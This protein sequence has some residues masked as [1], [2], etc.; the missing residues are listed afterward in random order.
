MAI[1]FDL[2]FIAYYGWRWSWSRLLH[3]ALIIRSRDIT[4]APSDSEILY[5]ALPVII[6][7]RYYRDF[8]TEADVKLSLIFV[9][10]DRVNF[11]SLI[12]KNIRISKTLICCQKKLLRKM[13]IEK[14][15]P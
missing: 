15:I 6:I 9:A 7:V 3:I 12:R 8:P 2:Y 11:L 1:L 10:R 5:S 14:E 4:L 13:K